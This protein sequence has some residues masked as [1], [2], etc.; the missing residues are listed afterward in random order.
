MRA[1]LKPSSSSPGKGSLA[2]AACFEQGS[3][4]LQADSGAQMLGFIGMHESCKAPGD[5]LIGNHQNV[6]Q[7]SVQSA[8]A[9]FG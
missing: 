6:V 9:A 7:R 5:I 1:N 8:L 4:L 2:C 3:A